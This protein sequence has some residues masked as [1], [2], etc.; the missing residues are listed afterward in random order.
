MSAWLAFGAAALILATAASALLV[1]HR[2]PVHLL[3]LLLAAAACAIVAVTLRLTLGPGALPERLWLLSVLVLLPTALVLYPDD[4]PPAGLGWAAPAVV[5]AAGGVAVLDAGRWTAGD[6]SVFVAYLLVL[7]VQ[8]WRY[9]HSDAA[10]RRALQWLS[11]GAVPGPV[12]AVLASFALPQQP[13]AVLHLAAWA[14]LVAC[15]YL[16]LSAPAVRDVRAMALSIAVH[17]ITTLLVVSV[18]AGIVAAVEVIAGGPVDFSPGAL[19]LVAAACAIGY[20]PF[21]RLFRQVLELLL[22]GARSDPIRAASQVGERLG[23]DPVPALRALREAL[24]LPY[25]AL[26]DDA[27][28]PIAVSGRPGESVV[29]RALTPGHLEIG[30][31]PGQLTLLRG[32][33]QVIAV[34]APA[35]AQLMQARELRA[36]LQTSRAAVVAAVEEERRR[37]RRDLHDGLGPRLT[38][39]AYASDAARNILHRDPERAA[40]LLAGVRAEAGEAIVEVRRLV[41]GLRPPSL[42]QVGLEQTI[43]QHARH[44]LGA[45]GR[46]MT[47][48]VHV[49]GPLPGLGAAVEVTA[50]R[51]VVEA[52]T[53]AARHSAGRH[54]DVVLRLDGAAALTIE[55]RDDGETGKAWIPGYGL[56]SMRERAEMLGGTLTA[57][58]GLVLAR[59]PL[60]PTGELRT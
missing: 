59:L 18:F 56:T 7:A 27:G 31:R 49:T 33:D 14:V 35:L 21:A 13:A 10:V 44:V 60:S 37:L 40:E 20:A 3:V 12:L 47:V 58:A 38:G 24:V 52:L 5:A 6:L 29:R 48:D 28:H 50:Y 43:R 16:G 9:E 42:D 26:L 8:W 4:R 11:L 2:G 39:L 1:R 34:L 51:I 17:A 23:E 19:G 55:V 57:D 22:F 53:N 25:A 41:E 54:A 15:L 36:A 32:D 30:L 46:P 45:D